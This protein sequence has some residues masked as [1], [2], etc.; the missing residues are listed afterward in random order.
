MSTRLFSRRGFLRNASLGV[1]AGLALPD[2]FLNR[3]FAQS[4]QNPSDFIRIGFIGLGGQGNS[5][6]GALLKNA[7]AV[8]DVDSEHLAKAKKRVED[9]NK[10]SCAAFKV[11]ATVPSAIDAT[12]AIEW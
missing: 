8:C 2:F 6:L 10:R 9:A 12:R 7:V 1:G 5:N 4:G 3:T 11:A